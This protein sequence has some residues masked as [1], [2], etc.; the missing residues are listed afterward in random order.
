MTTDAIRDTIQLAILHEQQSGNLA[1]LMNR[2]ATS[3]VHMT[4]KLPVSDTTTCLVDFVTAYIEHVP[5]CID[6]V[7]SK[8]THAGVDSFTEPF[9]NLAVDFFL[10]PKNAIQDRAGLNDL[11]DEAYLAHRLI[12]E[13]NDLLLVKASISLIP[14]DMSIS[15]LIVHSLIGEP[16]ANE[17][18]EAVHYTTE[19]A[20][21]RECVGNKRKLHAYL[22]WHGNET[23]IDAG[24]G[25]RH[26]GKPCLTEQFPIRLHFPH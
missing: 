20:G 21:S 17:L 25:T 19:K 6:T 9:L 26:S 3:N 11:M 14:V 15:N 5:F 22:A 4:V 10:K 7:R 12:E 16:F 1:S 23:G 18:D 2:Y 13:M 8:A 24:T